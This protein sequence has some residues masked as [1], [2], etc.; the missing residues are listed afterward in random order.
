M[1]KKVTSSNFSKLAYLS[2]AF[3]YALAFLGVGIEEMY[4]YITVI[5][6]CIGLLK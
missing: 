2:L 4:A 3:I 6:I 1:N 5:Y